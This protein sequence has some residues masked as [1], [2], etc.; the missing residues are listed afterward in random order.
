LRAFVVDAGLAA[1]AEP[2]EQERTVVCGPRHA[3]QLKRRAYRSGHARGELVMGG[4]RVSTDRPGARTVEGQE[5]ELPSW[6]FFSKEDPLT[7]R[8]LEQMLV[9]VSTR[10]YARSL[11]PMPAGVP[12]RGTSKSAVNRRFVAKTEAR[13]TEW[14][15]RDLSG[16]VLTVL[17]VDGVHVDEHVLLVALGKQARAGRS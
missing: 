3:R 6:R 13:M 2:L 4:R 10:Q 16:L 11:E 7:E 9:G 15:K 8:A 14:L 1:L 17:M 12:T 5:V